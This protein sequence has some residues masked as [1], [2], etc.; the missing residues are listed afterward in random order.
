MLNDFVDCAT[1]SI[2][3]LVFTPERDIFDEDMVSFLEDGLSDFDIVSLL[4]TLSSL[5]TV[6]NSKLVVLL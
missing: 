1:P 3:Y 6:V 2:C 5:F 4:V